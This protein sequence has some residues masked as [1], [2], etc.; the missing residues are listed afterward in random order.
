MESYYDLLIIGG[1]AAGMSAASQA[2]RENKEMS[3]ALFEKSDFVSYGSCGM[4]YYIGGI[5]SDYNKLIA[6][7]VD[8][9]VNKRNIQIMTNTEATGVDFKSKKVTAM[10]KGEKKE[11][12]YGK[13]MIA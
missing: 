2:R 4:P 10:H 9:F 11:I 6:I 1:V 3:I 7:D 12:S 5:I 13:M 8:K